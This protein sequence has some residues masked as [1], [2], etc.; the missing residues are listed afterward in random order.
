MKLLCNENFKIQTLAVD[1][2]AVNFFRDF[3]LSLSISIT[4]SPPTFAKCFKF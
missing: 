2:V 3:I 1:G 4:C